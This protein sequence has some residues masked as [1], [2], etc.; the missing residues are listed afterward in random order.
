MG[1]V[2]LDNGGGT[3]SF[4][5]LVQDIG[6]AQTNLGVTYILNADLELTLI[7]GN[8]GN[9]QFVKDALGFPVPQIGGTQTFDMSFPDPVLGANSTSGQMVYI[10]RGLVNAGYRFIAEFLQTVTIKPAVPARVD[11]ITARIDG[12]IANTVSGLRETSQ[13]SVG[14]DPNATLYSAPTVDFGA[15][16]T[17][18][19]GA[20]NTGT[21]LVGVNASVD[22][23]KTT[24]NSAVAAVINQLGGTEDTGVAM[25]N[26]SSN[27]SEVRGAVENTMSSVGATVSDISTTALGAVNTGKIVS[28]INSTVQTVAG[29][30]TIHRY[31]DQ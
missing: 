9:F 25:L 21:V 19:L 2:E 13:S 22:E 29:L 1:T 20:V 30:N 23:A 24:S 15:I 27:T 18:A 26:V 5:L 6:V 7:G 11:V 4:D 31:V 3:Q 17:T 12:S 28:G 10:P 16:A 14:L 8:L